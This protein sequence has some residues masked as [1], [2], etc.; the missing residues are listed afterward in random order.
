MTD[1]G[2]RQLIDEAAPGWLGRARTRTDKFRRVGRYQEQSG[3]WSEVK[4]VY[5]K[6]QHNKCGYC[7][8]KLADPERGIIEH[9]LEHFRPKS[10]VKAWPAPA[11]KAKFKLTF[12]T[13]AAERRGYYLLP[14]HPWNYL[15]ACKACNSALKSSAFPVAAV[16]NTAAEDPWSMAE[17][18]PFLV[19]PLGELDSDPATI[20]TFIGN[21]PVPVKRK[22]HAHRRAR[23]V[24]AF[25]ELDTREDLLEE[26][27]K[28]IVALWIALRLRATGTPDDQAQ[29]NEA[30]LQYTSPY[31]PH[32]RCITAFHELTQRD[33]AAAARVVQHMREYLRSKTPT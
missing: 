7:E 2:L 26:R 16:R 8:R 25:F 27:A 33:P 17:E 29:A 15:V 21:L 24:I 10:D 3:I 20:L 4:P 32:S 5:S 1:T 9:D 30:I 18:K 19:Y 11:A 6:L 23:V 22:G 28:W 31:A 14:Y 13:G 12:S